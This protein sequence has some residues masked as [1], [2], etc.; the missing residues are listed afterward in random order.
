MEHDEIEALLR[1]KTGEAIALKGVAA[2]VKLC[3]LLGEVEVEQRYL[4]SKNTNIEAVYTFPLPIGAVL[5]ALEVELD[6]RTLSGE[7]VEKQQAEA[8]YEEAITDGD[9]AVMLQYAGPG[10]YTMNLGNLKAGES[11]V[12]RYRYG[13]ALQWQAE[14]LRLLL[15]TTIAPRYGNPSPL[16]MQPHQVP[17][18]SSTV[19]YPFSIDIEAEGLL[20]Q[21]EVTSP[22]HTLAVAARDGKL[23]I[24]LAQAGAMDR[25]FV[26]LFKSAQSDSCLLVRD[27]DKFIALAAIR[28]PMLARKQALPLRMNV[29]I[30]C[31]GSMAGTSII[32]ARKAALEMLSQLRPGDQFNVTLFGS[33]HRHLFLHLTPVTPA[34]IAKAAEE[35]IHL[36]A[37]MGGTETGEALDACYRMAKRDAKELDGD[38]LQ[39]SILLI[40]D[41]QIHDYSSLL[42]KAKKSGQRLFSVGVGTVVA[43]GFVREIAEC[44]GGAF[45]LVSPQEGMAEV[46]LKQFHRLR[47]PKIEAVKLEWAEPPLWQTPLPTAVYAGDTILVWAAFARE[48]WGCVHLHFTLDGEHATSVM[49]HMVAQP[50]LARMAIAHHIEHLTGE[51]EKLALALEYQL[52]TP[53]TNFLV[54]A[55]REA[56]ME[57]LPQLQQVP[58]MAPAGWGG[59]QLS[60]KRAGLSASG[61]ERARDM[62]EA[63]KEMRGVSGAPMFASAA[64]A[65]MRS[66]MLEEMASAFDR[67]PEQAPSYFLDHLHKELGSA[68][69]AKKLPAT[70]LKLEELGVPQEVC[71]SLRE[72]MD[73][74][75]AQE[76][77]VVI[78]FLFA[79]S[80]GA[81][82]T[83]LEAALKRLILLG[84]KRSLPDEATLS[85]IRT[86]LAGAN[87]REW[88]W[89]LT[90]V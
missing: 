30:D 21:A 11:C 50:N 84:K 3:G 53:A 33:D 36:Q 6:G 22:T 24:A 38:T 37:D 54:V 47:Q 88:N 7:I 65:P 45:E 14:H 48:P 31:S 12:I 72:I 79:L 46:I 43:E 71:A 23:H 51:P 4:N 58:Q 68:L 15:P 10:L 27:D 52:L 44:T 41:G 73:R 69:D 62:M 55:E 78:A 8:A 20:A 34:N 28:V 61:A 19:S 60:K 70:L 74:S 86:A 2:R 64:A 42:T 49:P 85:T 81:L 32:Q 5:L 40:T 76:Q 67:A 75:G 18:T 26:L 9:S 16:E 57:T 83:Y 35:L 59:M 17:V 13:M 66:A 82:Q 80:T 77:Q 1:D 90:V 29:V 56:K 63:A 25:D 39:D 89:P 87:E